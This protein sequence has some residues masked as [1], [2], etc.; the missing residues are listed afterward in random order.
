VPPASSTVPA[1]TRRER[2]VRPRFAVVTL[3]ATLNGTAKNATLRAALHRHSFWNKLQYCQRHGYDLIIEGDDA[4]DARRAPQWS[5]LRVLRKW[6]PLYEWVLWVD[7]DALFTNWSFTIEDLVFDQLDDM[8]AQEQHQQ[9]QVQQQ[10]QQQQNALGLGLGV[11]VASREVDLIATHDWNGLNTGVMLL[12]NSSWARGFLARAAQV[13]QRLA[14]P[15]F[16]QG[17]IHHLLYRAGGD[18][19]LRHVWDVDNN[20]LNSYAAV[21]IREEKDLVYQHD[22]A[23]DW[24]VHLPGCRFAAGCVEWFEYYAEESLCRNGAAPHDW[25]ITAAI[26]PASYLPSAID[27]DAASRALLPPLS[28][29]DPSMDGTA[30]HP[31]V[32]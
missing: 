26:M 4:V 16:D 12:R 30:F 13:P 3:A 20:F 24:I 28:E 15:Y 29:Y 7:G 27:A 21:A 6:L 1:F 31:A 14:D 2:N 25:A 10:Q 8:L 19:D 18:L 5:K 17:A 22:D 23:T 9:Q 32:L 11:G